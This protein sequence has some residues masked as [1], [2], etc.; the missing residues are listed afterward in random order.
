MPIFYGEV[1]PHTC[2]PENNTILERYSTP[3]TSLDCQWDCKMKTSYVNDFDMIC[4]GKNR[5][6]FVLSFIFFAHLVG[7]L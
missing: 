5:A 3:N 4:D 2:H 7:G 1:M 6:Q